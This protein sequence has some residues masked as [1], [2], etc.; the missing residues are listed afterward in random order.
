MPSGDPQAMRRW[1]Q[2]EVQNRTTTSRLLV[3]TAAAASWPPFSRVV[4][5]IATA[6]RTVPAHAHEGEE[7]LTWV[8][9]GF[10]SYQFQAEPATPVSANSVRLLCAP[11]KVTHR[12]SPSQ[13][14]TVRWLS[15]VVGL[16]VGGADGPALFA[17]SPGPS[18]TQG[19]GTVMRALAGPGS[20]IPTRSGLRARE[21]RFV[22]VGTTFQAIG[23]GRSA[24]AYV[25]SGR[26]SIDDQPVDVGEG[27]LLGDV[28]GV[29]IHGQPGLQ[30]ILASAPR[31]GS[32]QAS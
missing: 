13:G 10:A 4:E 12:V 1:V 23:H 19:D 17:A 28:A 29:A 6:Q 26:G 14:G 2:G 31:P 15:L 9:E 5:T 24:V 7:V 22:A 20:E 32:P 8:V 30:L 11:T 21:I 25:L 27:M 3:P 16:P 18:E